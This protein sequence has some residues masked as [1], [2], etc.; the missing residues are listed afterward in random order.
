MNKKDTIVVGTQMP[1]HI[2]F[3]DCCGFFN[4]LRDEGLFCNECGMEISKAIGEFYNEVKDTISDMWGGSKQGVHMNFN[5]CETDA[6]RKWIALS[7]KLG[8]LEKPIIS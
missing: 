5:G 4:D 8:I 1:A 7:E 2:D 3:S 6:Y